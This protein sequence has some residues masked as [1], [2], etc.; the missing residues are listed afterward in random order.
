MCSSLPFVVIT[1]KVK[2]YLFQE[3][4]Q[5]MDIQYNKKRSDITFCT[6]LFKMPDHNKL[7][8]IKRY[9]RKFEE[10]YLKSLQKL[11]TTF[12]RVALWC[13]HETAVFL[14]KHGLDKKVQMRVMKYSDLPHYHE[15]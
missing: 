8:K 4:R 1:Y 11:I 5:E 7:G 2:T 13:D 9:D 10:F 3:G 15:R 14:K 12:E 6:M